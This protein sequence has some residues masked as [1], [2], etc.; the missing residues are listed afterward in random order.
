L[1]MTRPEG[2]VVAAIG[3]LPLLVSDHV[4]MRVKSLALAAWGAGTLAWYGYSAL[5][6]AHLDYRPSLIVVGP[7]ALGALALA[8]AAAAARV[9][10]IKTIRSEPWSRPFLLGVELALW[11]GLMLF[12]ARDLGLLT[13][14]ANA[15]LRNQLQSGWGVTVVG[16]AVLV[17]VT[18]LLVRDRS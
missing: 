7:A 10:R 2:A 18:L 9:T 12:A 15:T 17:A 8:I 4:S 3:I 14:S 11:A 5:I 16:L 6:L 1:I 13:R